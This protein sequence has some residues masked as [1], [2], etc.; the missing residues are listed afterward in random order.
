[1]ARI[2]GRCLRTVAP[3]CLSL[4]ALVA[5]SSQV[6][7][8]VANGDTRTLDIYHTHT[9]ESASI[10]YKRNGS[11]DRAALDKLNWILRDWRRD[12]PTNMDPRLFDIVWEVH[13]EVGSNE[14]LHIVSA[15]RAPETNAMLRRRSRAVAKHSQHLSLIHI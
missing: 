11:Y 10:T 2:V 8:A 6:G 9:K 1:M 12:E 14:P 7:N 3:G 13:R 4:A 5:A 15:Y